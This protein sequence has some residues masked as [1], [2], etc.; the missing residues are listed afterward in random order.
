MTT[1]DFGRAVAAEAEKQR[2]QQALDANT[3]MM[4]GVYQSSKAYTNSIILGGYAVFFTVW[5]F[6]RDDAARGA[7]LWAALLA[8]FS[9]SVFVIFE[10][11]KM[12]WT[13][14]IIQRQLSIGDRPGGLEANA[15]LV[16]ETTERELKTFG[17]IWIFVLIATIIPAV[18]AY[19][20]V[21]ANIVLELV[22]ES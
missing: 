9:A 7:M 14:R 13:G 12:I 4:S 20:I 18:A 11:Y 5:A 3:D 16:K 21:I 15:Q 10:V 8:I 2:R 19:A 6:V 22:S 1:D 17:K